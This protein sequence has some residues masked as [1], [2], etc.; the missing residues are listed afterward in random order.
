[1]TSTPTAA[2][3]SGRGR[4]ERALHVLAF[5]LLLGVVGAVVAPLFGKTDTLGAQDWDQMEAHRYLAV[6]TIEKYHQFPFWNPYGCGGHTWWGGI[7]SGTNLVSPWLPA[8]LLAPLPWAVRLEVVGA[9]LLGAIGAWTF[10][11]RLTRSPG[12]RLLCACAFAVN[13]RWALQT[14]SGH[15]WHLYYAWM[16]WALWLFDRA[17]AAPPGKAKRDVVGLGVVLAA[18]V[19][20]GAI[21]PLPQVIIVIALYG[22]VA[23]V[24]LRSVRPLALALGGGLLSFA[25]AAPRLLPVIDVLRRY[26]RL[27]DS[28]ETIDLAGIIGIF[29]SRQGEARPAVGPWGWHEF[30]FYIGWLPFLLMLSAPFL[31]R[32]WKERAALLAGSACFVLALGSFSPMAPWALLHDHVPV[33][34]SQHVPSRWFYPAVLL[35][36][37][38]AAAACERW[39]RRVPRGR[40]LLEL[41]LLATAGYVGF[42]I[43]LQSQPDVA[44]TFV[45]GAPTVGPSV[46]PYHQEKTAPA[47]LRYPVPDWAP[48]ALPAMV[49]NVGVIDCVTFPGLNTYYRDRKGRAPG[50]GAKGVGDGDYRG[51]TYFASG[52]GAAVVDGWTPNVVTVR[53]TGAA[54]GDLL[55]LNQNWDPGWSAE[56]GVVNWKDVAAT[57][58]S[59]GSGVV[60]FRY[61]PRFFVLGCVILFGTTFALL[62]LPYARRWRRREVTD[63]AA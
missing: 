34:Q 22:L 36:L 55:V 46:G 52:P 14:E 59:A 10:V 13:G 56:R 12:L 2:A 16:P 3:P 27:V 54:E 24:A 50:L 11:G 19:Y 32:R 18:M 23:A 44:G 8:Y 33:F 6:K 40:L 4:K 9:A 7:E 57:P 1:M 43:A 15:T 35:L 58:V 25:F 49:A 45:R 42:D 38:S 62:L 20:T 29:T 37:A 26:P 48:P 61:R 28:P 5:L 39:L 17:I 30:G 63:V 21:Y 47:E 41:A 31:A 53:Y 51:E 60:V